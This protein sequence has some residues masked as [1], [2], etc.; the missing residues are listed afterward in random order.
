MFIALLMLSA[1]FVIFYVIFKLLQVLYRILTRKPEE[2]LDT[3]ET[4]APIRDE[5]YYQKLKQFPKDLFE[6][7]V[8]DQV[9]VDLSIDD[10]SV[11]ELVETPTNEFGI[12]GTPQT[13]GSK[14]SN[15]FI[16]EVVFA[17]KAKFGLPKRTEAN[18]VAVRDYAVRIMKEVGHRPS[19]ICRDVP[20]IVRLVFTPTDEEIRQLRIECNPDAAYRRKVYN[21]FSHA[22]GNQ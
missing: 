14:Q 4:T 19:H 9:I 20:K 11:E 18:R 22:A 2:L 8:K 6:E 21:H 3:A 15:R 13:R 12:S 5:I 16:R 1:V 10:Y 7:Y 17:V